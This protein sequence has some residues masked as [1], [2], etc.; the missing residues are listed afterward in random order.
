MSGQGDRSGTFEQGTERIMMIRK[1]REETYIILYN[2][3]NCYGCAQFMFERRAFFLSDRKGEMLGN[4]C[5]G[6]S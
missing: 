5:N 3:H 1:Q 2:S 6:L 4:G